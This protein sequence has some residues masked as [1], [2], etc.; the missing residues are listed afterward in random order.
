MENL[1]KRLFGQSSTYA[2]GKVLTKGVGLLLLPLYTRYLSTEDYGVLAVATVVTGLLSTALTGGARGSALKFYFEY[3]GND[4]RRFYG[5][6]STTLVFGA[7]ALFVLFDTFGDTIFGVLFEQV[8]FHPY[9]RMAL[10][11]A[12]LTGVFVVTTKEMLKA[13]EQAL[14]F[15]GINIAVFAFSTGLTIWWV[16]YEGQ[17]AEGAIRGKLVG[18]GIV[19]LACAGYLLWY[20]RPAL[21]TSMIRRSFRYS[22]PLVPHFLAHW[23]L[24]AAD[25]IILERMVTLSEVGVYNVGYQIGAGMSIIATSGNNAIVSLFGKFDTSEQKNVEKVGEIFTYYI[26]VVTVIALCV[27]L[28]GEDLVLIATPKEYHGAGSIIPWVAAG[29]VFMALYFSPTNTLTITSGKSGT[30]G[31][32]T[33]IGALS[34]II[35]NISLIPLLGVYGAAITTTVT[36]MLMFVG[37]YIIASSLLPVPMELRRITQILAAACLTFGVGWSMAPEN[38]IHSVLFKSNMLLLF[39]IS[40]WGLR[41][42]RDK[43]VIYIQNVIG[44]IMSK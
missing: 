6:L 27:S 4:R 21:D 10:W 32:A 7:G 41:F 29:Y 23:V 5:S 24:S 20:M 33:T 35:L 11:T 31:V 12:Y 43:E 36:Y 3:E 26:L 9:I 2:F 28:F 25:R 38:I 18:T 40:L 1:L 17:G 44:R 19:A 42:F 37:V 34:N 15:T 39:P 30:I 22:L 14:A 13:G 8:A 16:V